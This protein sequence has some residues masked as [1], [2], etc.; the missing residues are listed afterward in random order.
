MINKG[1]RVE[2]ILA[3]T[4]DRQD[5]LFPARRMWKMVRLDPGLGPRQ[6][7]KLGGVWI[8]LISWR[9][10][11][12]GRAWSSCRNVGIRRRKGRVY[13]K[14]SNARLRAARLFVSCSEKCTQRLRP[15]E[16]SLNR[17]R[18]TVSWADCSLR[19][20]GGSIERSIEWFNHDI[21]TFCLKS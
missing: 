5:R 10:W 8:F 9:S 18:S 17:C 15:G 21:A 1:R 13:F 19:H 7:N 2:G 16:P 6:F 20:C 14:S 12:G 3:I 4:R 11:M